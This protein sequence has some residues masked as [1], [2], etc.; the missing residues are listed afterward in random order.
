MFRVC[1]KST[2]KNKADAMV[3]ALQDKS[4]KKF[5]QNIRKSKKS[6]LPSTV[7]GRRAT[8]GGGIWGICLPTEISKHCIA[9]FTFVETFKE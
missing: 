6:W 7:G 8:R 3:A 1:R 4:P 5:W 2:E 9:I